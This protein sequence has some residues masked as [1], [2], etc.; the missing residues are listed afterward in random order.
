MGWTEGE[1][2]ESTTSIDP[3]AFRSPRDR[4]A[5]RDR[6]PI[7]EV[8]VE[9]AAPGL[10]DRPAENLAAIGLS[11]VLPA[12]NEERGVAAVLRRIPRQGLRRLGYSATIYLLDGR[13]TDRTRA[14]A[15]RLGASVFVQSGRG[16]GSAFREFVPTITERFTVVLDSDGTYPPEMIPRLVKKLRAGNPVV[17]GS[18]IRGSIER[19]AMSNANLLGNRLLSGFASLLF[20][21]RISDVCSGMWA[22]DSGKLKSLGLTAEGFEL[23]AD[24]FAECSLQGIPIVEIPI[25]YSKR[26]GEPKLRL[27]EGLRI[28][29]ALLRKRIHGKEP[30]PVEPIVAER[31]EIFG[32]AGPE[33]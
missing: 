22:F 3:E 9:N 27:R 20:R 17:V 19:G 4:S 6:S 14:V 21:T 11:I 12:L 25:P 28:A 10:L 2:H 32:P 5:A 1:W 29:F 23:E 15:E 31:T 18:R 33:A 13:S 26:I 24:I 16:K 7:P 30:R 8:G